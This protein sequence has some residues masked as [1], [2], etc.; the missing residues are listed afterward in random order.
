MND[1][2]PTSL[3][4]Y[5]AM[6]R[7]IDAAFEVDEV[8]DIRDKAAALEQLAAVR[9]HCFWFPQSCGVYVFDHPEGVLY[10]GES[11]NLRKRLTSGHE[12]GYLRRSIDV[13]CRALVCANHK[14]V[15]R[16][17]IAELMPVLNGISEQTRRRRPRMPHK[18][19]E[20][21]DSDTGHMW[22]ELFGADD[23]SR[24]FDPTARIARGHLAFRYEPRSKPSEPELFEGLQL[25]YPVV[26]GHDEEPRYV[27]RDL[28]SDTDVGWNVSRLRAGGQAKPD[29][30]DA[31]EAWNASRRA[32]A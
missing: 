23:W 13:R 18:T 8:K 27:L 1:A 2:S 11:R 12:R 26:H 6:C 17:L 9:G 24:T 29:H 7:A 32:S 3:V 16:W 21:V 10:V 20:E 25:R 28:L 5:D 15:E 4:R 22:S 30:A 14:Q 19:P 31:L